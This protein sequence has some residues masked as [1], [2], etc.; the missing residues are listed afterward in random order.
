MNMAL[1]LNLQLIII[2]KAVRQIEVWW[3]V[4]RNVFIGV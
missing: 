4:C 2:Y 1:D 3:S